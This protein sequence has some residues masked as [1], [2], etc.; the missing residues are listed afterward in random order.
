MEEKSTTY[1]I[2]FFKYDDSTIWQKTGMQKDKKILEEYMKT[3][4]YCDQSTIKIKDFQL[5]N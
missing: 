2:G 4:P 1:Y 5:P 3:I